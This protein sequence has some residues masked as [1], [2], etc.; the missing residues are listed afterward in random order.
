MHLIPNELVFGV[1][2]EILVDCARQIHLRD[3]KPFSLNEFSEAL[4]APTRE[5]KPVLEQM[6][7]EGFFQLDAADSGLYRPTPKLG[8]LA[9]ASISN[10]LTRADAVK[11]LERVIER[12]RVINSDPDKYACEVVCLVVF[13]SYLTDKSVLGDLDFGVEL[14]EISRKDRR[15]PAMGILELLRRASPTSKAMSALRLQK[16]KQISVHKLDEVICLGTAYEI[17]FGEMKPSSSA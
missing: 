11:L 4:G 13:G 8:Q 16:P 17:V 9:L 15:R 2:P 10:G 3:L 12:A 5:S 7:A 6:V 14:R 1:A